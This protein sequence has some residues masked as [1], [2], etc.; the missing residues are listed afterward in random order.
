MSH[1]TRT[2]Q[3]IAGSNNPSS[4]A[5]PSH[6]TRTTPDGMTT[7]NMMQKQAAIDAAKRLADVMKSPAADDYEDD[8]DGVGDIHLTIPLYK[9]PQKINPSTRIRDAGTPSSVAS[10]VTPNYKPK[11]FD[12]KKKRQLS[13]DNSSVHSSSSEKLSSLLDQPINKETENKSP[14]VI[15]SKPILTS[16]TLIYRPSP[17][18]RIHQPDNP[19]IKTETRLNI[20]PS[21]ASDSFEDEIEILHEENEKITEKLR[22][23]EERYEKAEARAHQLEKQ[24]ASL[25]AGVSVE[26]KL[27]SRKEALLRE[28]EA[29]LARQFDEQNKSDR[30]NEIVS[31]QQEVESAKEEYE[32]AKKQLQCAQSEVETLTSVTDKMILTQEEL[33][34]VVLK[35]CWLSRYWALAIQ[36]GV[37]PDIAVS[38]HEYWSSLAPL[39]LEVVLSAGQKAKEGSRHGGDDNIERNKVVDD[40]GDVTGE[41]NIESMLSVEQGLRE[42]ASLKVED[43]VVLIMAHRRQ[44]KLT[45]QSVSDPKEPGNLNFME[46]LELSLEELEDVSFKQAWLTYFWEKAKTKGVEEDIADERL[47]FW[48][49][50][51]GQ[52]PTAHDAVDVERGL[53][54][55]RKLGIEQQ[56]WEVSRRKMDQKS[57]TDLE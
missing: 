16:E 15:S 33:E 32:N 41:G 17:S 44:H 31:L 38:K 48:I 51:S 43:A 8:E 12:Y 11:Q 39:P 50:R 57:S 29:A 20:I 53:I 2:R 30:D 37:Y 46:A 47:Q 27:L 24:V 25:G 26:D 45:Q 14:L 23:T 6:R 5:R 28:R 42:L 55:L 21:M 56:L 1:R 40:L 52:T 35:R 7:V 54:E 10:K 22:L 9:R 49:S 3:P 34:E 4:P 18:I 19:N 36:F 13:E